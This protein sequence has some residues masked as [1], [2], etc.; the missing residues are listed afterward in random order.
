M[1]NYNNIKK[2]N[3]T[4]NLKIIEENLNLIKEEVEVI[5]IK[6]N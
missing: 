5:L 3:K 2:N 6:I 4:N 1:K